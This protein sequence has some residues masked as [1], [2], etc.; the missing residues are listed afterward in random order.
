[1]ECEAIDG[2]SRKHHIVEVAVTKLNPCVRD[3][4]IQYCVLKRRI[5]G[6]KSIKSGL[7]QLRLLERRCDDRRIGEITAVEFCPSEVT[8]T[9][10]RS[11]ECR[12]A[13]I[14]TST[15]VH[16]AECRIGEVGTA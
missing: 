1:M 9:D 13:E 3:R 16:P 11:S 14:D 12:V 5:D 2:R 8:F 4:L 7:T 15:K 10:R 6:S